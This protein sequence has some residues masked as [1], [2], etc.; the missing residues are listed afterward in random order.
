MISIK[1][2]FLL[3]MTGVVI[4]GC[5][6]QASQQTNPPAPAAAPLSLPATPVVEAA[7]N[8]VGRY[9]EEIYDLVKS[10]DWPKAKS[11]LVSLKQAASKLP[12]EVNGNG[13]EQVQ[14]N[15]TMRA[16]DTAITEKNW[17]RAT[18]EANQITW[19]GADLTAPF[20][21]L[22][23]IEVTRLDYYGRELEISSIQKDEPRLKATA[24]GMVTAW[25]ALRPPLEAAGGVSEAERF[26]KLIAQVEAA[27]SPADF[28]KLAAPV[29][30]EVDNLEKVFTGK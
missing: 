28:G 13:T 1:M 18:R 10:G 4:G 20:K 12:A 17:E 19:I 16:L 8:D 23:P 27:Q 7:I 2:T 6:P 11:D 14:L 30:D 22:V 15:E 3:A 9:G 25:N 24:A 26:G 29:L 21:P 5:S